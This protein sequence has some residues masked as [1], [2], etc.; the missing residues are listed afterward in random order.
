MFSVLLDLP[1]IAAVKRLRSP[2]PNRPVP[3]PVLRW[4]LS[5]KADPVSRKAIG[6]GLALGLVFGVAIHNFALGI[7]IGV[8]IGGGVAANAK[9]KGR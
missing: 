3:S 5:M 4:K 6:I 2:G 9:R 7:L 1:L 8:A